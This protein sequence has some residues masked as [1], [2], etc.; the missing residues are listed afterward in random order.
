MV[1][2]LSFST[3]HS[4]LGHLSVDAQCIVFRH[5]NFPSLNK[6]NDFCSSC[7][8]SKA[9]RLSTISTTIYNKLLELIYSD[10][11][12]L[13]LLT[14][15]YGF[16]Y[17]ATFIDA[18]THFTWL[19]LLKIKSETLQ[20]FKQFQFQLPL[21]ALQIDW[22]T[23]YRVFTN[24]LAQYGI[25]HYVICPHTHYQNRVVEINH[26][27]IVEF[28]FTLLTY[29]VLPFKISDYAFS[30][31][32]YLINRLLTSFLHFAI[33]YHKLFS[34][35][36]D[37]NFLKIF[38]CPCFPLLHPY[39]RNKLQF[40]SQE[41]VFL[42]YS[43]SHKGYRCL[44]HDD[45]IFNQLRFPYHELF[46]NPSPTWYLV[47]KYEYSALIRNNTWTLVLLPP[48][49]HLISCKWVFRVKEN[50]DDSIKKHK[51]Q[52]VTKGFHQRPSFDYN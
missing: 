29:V 7:C 30:T 21:K 24:Y 33:P 39:N 31:R 28:G 1:P 19:Y 52:L 3:W 43:T 10:L 44:S 41:C 26:R 23:E 48:D 32:V 5:Y 2:S 50:H 34:Q 11:W 27:H 22:G 49:R 45:M 35:L 25:M 40:R 14:S 8:L 13:A 47:M 46:P 37:Y 15:A 51:A 36:L 17:Y 20:V 38:G 16:T 18:Y 6:N 12:G 9:H 4:R 42:R